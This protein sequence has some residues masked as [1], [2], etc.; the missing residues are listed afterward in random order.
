MA[1]Q[2]RM[3][4]IWVSLLPSMVLL[5]S[6]FASEILSVALHSSLNFAGMIMILPGVALGIWSLATPT[7]QMLRISWPISILF[8]IGGGIYFSSYWTYMQNGAR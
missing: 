6:G 4:R 7:R 5:A 2:S 1:S 8:L 3:V